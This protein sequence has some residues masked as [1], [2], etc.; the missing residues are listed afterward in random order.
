MT[1]NLKS[2]LLKNNEELKNVIQDV[3]ALSG[4]SQTVVKEC[5][6][7]LLYVWALKIIDNP[8]NFAELDIPYIGKLLVKYKKDKINPDNSITT[9]IE[10]HINVSD[11][12]KN[13]IGELHDEGYTELVTLM[14]KKI[15]NVII[16]SVD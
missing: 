9:E 11:D 8:D 14:E 12:F 6:E 4:Y 5:F 10:S 16:N 1:N 7:Y 2:N 3:C 13:L 15:E